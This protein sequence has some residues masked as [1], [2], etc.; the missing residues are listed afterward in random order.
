MP[1]SG[2]SAWHKGL[3]DDGSAMGP[4][5]ALTSLPD[6]AILLMI[7]RCPGI[8]AAA[9]TRELRVI[10]GIPHSH[11]SCVMRIKEIKE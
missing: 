7:S 2:R 10:G 1:E 5:P 11:H 3:G 8:V 4:S 9:L 6:G